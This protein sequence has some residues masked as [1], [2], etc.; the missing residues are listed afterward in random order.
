MPEVVKRYGIQI[1]LQNRIKDEFNIGEGD[2]GIKEITTKSGRGY[3]MDRYGNMYN[4]K[5][6]QK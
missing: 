3:G 1:I 6:R 4:L 5:T 2:W